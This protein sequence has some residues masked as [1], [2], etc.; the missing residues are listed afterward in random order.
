MKTSRKL[1]Q[2]KLAMALREAVGFRGPTTA[3]HRQTLQARCLRYRLNLQG[4]QLQVMVVQVLG[5]RKKK[6]QVSQSQF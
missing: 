6:V 4:L 3:D 2:R 1:L 5:L